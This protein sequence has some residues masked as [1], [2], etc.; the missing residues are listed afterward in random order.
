MIPCLSFRPLIELENY[1]HSMGGV[2]GRKKNPTTLP[3]SNVC[4]I[5]CTVL[6]RYLVN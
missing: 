1:S 5:Y 3:D 4:V 6:L 2:R